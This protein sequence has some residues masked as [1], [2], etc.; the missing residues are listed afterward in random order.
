MKFAEQVY[1]ARR[2]YNMHDI[3]NTDKKKM[4]C[5]LPMHVHQNNTPS[6]S[7]FTRPNGD[8]WFSC[9]GNCQAEGDV[10]DLVGYLRI[11]GYSPKDFKA[12]KKAIGMLSDRFTVATEPFHKKREETKLTGHEWKEFVPY[13]S[14]VREY[15]ESRGITEETLKHFSV[16]ETNNWIA[17]PTFEDHRLICLKMRNMN[18]YSSFRYM[19]LEGSRLGLFNFDEI[20]MIDEPV[21]IAKGEITAMLMWQHGFHACA[22][23]GGES[24][25]QNIDHWFAALAFSPMKIVVGDNDKAGRKF[26]KK[27]A[28]MLYAELKFPP[29]QYKDWDDWLLAEPA[30]CIEETR[31]WISDAGKRRIP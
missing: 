20:N 30:Q 16:G 12:R 26:G 8:Q 9:F 18:R 31:R 5:P 21:L 6:F 19:S 22:P 24:S 14:A 13:G 29:E 4:V 7:I 23:T 1:E 27:R 10:I 15:A 11:P 3:L 2:S 17:I 28:G 25:H